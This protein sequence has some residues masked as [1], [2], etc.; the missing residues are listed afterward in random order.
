MN[1][2]ECECYY[3]L[4]NYKKFH[5]NGKIALK[6]KELSVDIYSTKVLI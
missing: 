1:G 5:K 6:K 3:D 2:I 4:K